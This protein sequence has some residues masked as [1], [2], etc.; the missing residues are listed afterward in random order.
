MVYKK[1]KVYFYW[2]KISF[3]LSWGQYCVFIKLKYHYIWHKVNI[4]YFYIEFYS[5]LSATQSLQVI[6]MLKIVIKKYSF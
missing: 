2:T 6:N 3:R 4:A 5:W 1:H